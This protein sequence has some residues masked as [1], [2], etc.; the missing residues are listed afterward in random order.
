MIKKLIQYILL[1]YGSKFTNYL[2]NKYNMCWYPYTVPMMFE[3]YMKSNLKIKDLTQEEYKLLANYVW[4]YFI[5][6]FPVTDE[7]IKQYLNEKV[8]YKYN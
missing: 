8:C 1:N 5:T 7:F 4:N 6:K 2:I 3:I